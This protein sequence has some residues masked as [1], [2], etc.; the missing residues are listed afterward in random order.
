[1][2]PTV[3]LIGGG[4]AITAAVIGWFAQITVA[5]LKGSGANASFPRNGSLT[6][7]IDGRIALHTTT[8]A[9]LRTILDMLSERRE[10]MKEHLREH[11]EQAERQQDHWH[12][13]LGK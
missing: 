11:R 13:P 12:D 4:A 2:D 5:S 8:C 6:S 1:M 7:V 10:D 3:A 9:N